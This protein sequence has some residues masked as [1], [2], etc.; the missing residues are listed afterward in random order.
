L[1]KFLKNF[2]KLVLVENNAVGQFGQLLRQETGIEIE[3]KI[4]KYD[5][6]PFWSDE[7]IQR[8]SSRGPR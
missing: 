2:N 4:L 3:K 5:G 1:E 6:R 8:L 7:I